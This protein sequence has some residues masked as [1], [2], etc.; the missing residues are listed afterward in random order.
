VI[1][2]MDFVS[3]LMTSA[4]LGG[5]AAVAGGG[6]FADAG[7]TAS[8]GYLFNLVS[9]KFVRATGLLTLTDTDTNESVTG[10]FFSGGLVRRFLACR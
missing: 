5:A 10:R 1:A 7:Q 8:F 2:K 9:G 4:A 3:G 6:K